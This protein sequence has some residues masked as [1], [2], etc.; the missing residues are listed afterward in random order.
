MDAFESAPAAGVGAGAF[1]DWWAQNATIAVF[2][3]NPHS[4]PLQQ[5]SELGLLGLLLLLGFGAAVGLAAIRRLSAGRDGDGGVMVAVLAAAALS[6]AIDWTWSIP[7]V[8]APAVIVSALLTA[9]APGRELT[10]DG[11]WLGL[12]AVATAWVSMVAGGLVVLS[13][14]K[15]DQSRDAAA[16]NRLDD[17][18]ERAEEAK[19]V[20]PFSP[21]PYVQLALVEELRGDLDRAVERLRQAQRRDTEDWRLALIEVRLQTGR[22]DEAAAQTAYERAGELNNLSVTTEEGQNRSR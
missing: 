4:L 17:A 5:A 20:L 18:V 15:L 3:R 1:E 8:A 7:A 19:T 10:R 16:E 22:G 12:G 21:E 13:E 14:L 9:S 2:V 6:S 11:Y